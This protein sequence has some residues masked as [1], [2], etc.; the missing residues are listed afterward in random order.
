MPHKAN[1][2][3]HLLQFAEPYKKT[4]IAAIVA[5]MVTSGLGLS[6]GMAVRRLIDDGFVAQ[7]LDGL[8]YSALFAMTIILF[9]AMGTYLRFYL[10]SWLGE[11]ISADLRSAV[12]DHLITLQPSYFETNRSG[13]IM[14]RLTTDTT[15]L[16]S[17]IGSSFSMALRSSLTL[18]GALVMMFVTHL[19]LTLMVL[20][21]VP[22]ILLPI[23]IFGKK[24][25]KLSRS[26]QDS[27]ANVGTVAGETIQNIKTVQSYH[28]EKLESNHFHHEVEQAFDVAIR[29]IQQRAIMI[30]AVILLV[31]GSITIMLWK[32]G[33]DVVMGQLSAGD[34][35]AF[36][37][38]AVMVGGAVATIS[39]VLG[40]IQRGAGA[41]ERLIELLNVNSLI[42]KPNQN[43]Q[44]AQQ[45]APVFT[46][47]NIEFSYPSRPNQKALQDF[48][49]SIQAGSSLALVGPSGAGKSTV[50]ELL[51]RFYDP[52]KGVIQLDGVDLRQLDPTQLRHKMALVSQQPALFSEDVFYNIR[53]GSPDASDEMVIEAAKAAFAHEFIEQLPEGYSSHLGEK[54][55]RLSG[56][57][58]QRIAI[59]RALL[60]NPQ[61]LLLDEATSALDS[62]SEAKVQTALLTLMKNRTTIIIAHRLATILHV[63]NIALMNEGQLIALGDHQQLMENSELYRNLA[64]LQFIQ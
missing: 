39:E 33:Q 7:S 30:A 62:E 26:S 22:F 46:F 54:G 5:L 14:S 49:L 29:R 10:V 56:G 2:L 50:L 57:Q 48:S 45:L 41:T 31:F 24:I 4:I 3:K 38:Y 12:F 17:I 36:I 27:I 35:G 61:I 55:I 20:S 52:Q 63:D 42:Q 58:K 23:L 37:F 32:G 43:C 11:R 1:P 15:L 64:N 59:A 13:E 25:K 28:N 44:D 53:Y 51:Q 8:G 9:L 34:L 21:G 6:L 47:E 19:K 18:I 40:E 60:K 16:Q